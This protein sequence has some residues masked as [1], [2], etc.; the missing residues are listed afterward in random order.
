MPATWLTTCASGNAIVDTGESYREYQYVWTAWSASAGFG[1]KKQYRTITPSTKRWHAIDAS[2]LPP[3][4]STLVNSLLG[5][6]GCVRVRWQEA[7]AGRY[8]VT[9]FFE[10]AGAWTDEA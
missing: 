8:T 7:G 3:A 10:T 1:R 5:E 6:S 4:S 2:V 9:Q